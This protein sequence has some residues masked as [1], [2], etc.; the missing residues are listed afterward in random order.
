[1]SDS[2]DI[3][4]KEDT[5][6]EIP[7]DKAARMSFTGHL[8]EMR[9]R[10]V[11]TSIVLGILFF[12]GLT[13]SE[14]T[15]TYISNLVDMKLEKTIEEGIKKDQKADIEQDSAQEDTLIQIQVHLNAN[16]LN[17]IQNQLD[18]NELQKVQLQVEVSD[19]KPLLEKLM[20]E[21][22]G[23]SLEQLLNKKKK[24]PEWITLTPLE[25]F[26]VKIKIALYTAIALGI[27]Y[28]AY[29]ICAF[30]FPGLKPKEKYVIRFA[31]IAS[32]V[33]GILGILT[34]LFIV[35]PVVI[36]QLLKFAPDWV[37]TFLQ[38]EKTMSFIFKIVLGFALA[39]QFPIVILVSVYLDLVTPKM[40]REQ[41]KI[42]IV[43]IMIAAAILTPPDPASLMLMSAPLLILY[44]LSILMSYLVIRRR[45]PEENEGEA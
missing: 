10:M 7:D 1:M 20:V 15:L 14:E 4:P 37:G 45:T 32:F 36:P 26:M 39:F 25:A 13:F 28:I 3:I 11:H 18:A 9:T 30:V 2:H 23:Q 29:Q 27:P 35:F 5:S 16:D 6:D 8:G 43:V 33:L 34:A 21:V 24:G 22:Q 40:L 12:V 38:L 41:R 44:E 19:L 42:A 31:L 17:N